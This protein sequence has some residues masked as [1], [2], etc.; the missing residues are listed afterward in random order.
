MSDHP[1]IRLGSKIAVVGRDGEVHETIITSYTYKSGH[2]A[3]YPDL[4]WWQRVKRFWLTPK[5]WRKPLKPIIEAEPDIVTIGTHA[6]EAQALQDRQYAAMK[7][8]GAALDALRVLNDEP[9]DS[10]T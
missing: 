10:N 9:D 5:R 2:P 8:I 7:R 4:S 1:D 6:D 3:I